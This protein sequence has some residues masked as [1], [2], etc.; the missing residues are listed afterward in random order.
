MDK[1]FIFELITRDGQY[2]AKNI[3]KYY[4]TSI[5]DIQDIIL[6]NP[7]KR[8]K[9]L[10]EMHSKSP[11]MLPDD[12]QIAIS[13]RK[14]NKITRID[15]SSIIE[16]EAGA[17]VTELYQFLNKEKL[18]IPIGTL[19]P[20]FNLGAIAGTSHYAFS[21]RPDLPEYSVIFSSQIISYKVIIASGECI[22]ISEQSHPELLPIIRC[23]WGMLGIICS[24]RLKAYPAVAYFQ[25]VHV[26][27]MKEFLDSIGLIKSSSRYHSIVVPAIDKVFI[28]QTTRGREEDFRQNSHNMLLRMS[29]SLLS[30]YLNCKNI[31]SRRIS[32]ELMKKIVLPVNVRFDPHYS[33]FP[34]SLHNITLYEWQ[35]K[36]KDFCNVLPLV[37]QLVEK[38]K[39]PM[40]IIIIRTPKDSNGL[41]YPNYANDLYTID[42]NINK[43]IALQDFLSEWRTLAI[44]HNAFVSPFKNSTILHEDIIRTYGQERVDLFLDVIQKW[45]PQGIFTNSYLRN[46]FDI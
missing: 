14:M 34:E 6:N 35:F 43:D 9:V 27:N 39:Y 29:V 23:H 19:E 31:F 8:V 38:S 28:L 22:E 15:N 5:N 42:I 12:D 33:K 40:D 24:F 4:P 44:Q 37:C 41:M 7:S 30:S 10:G 45:D 26:Y 3:D 2:S 16:I 13:L 20:I 11:C 18:Q 46:L 1:T 36:W 25:R 17:V 21:L 32:E